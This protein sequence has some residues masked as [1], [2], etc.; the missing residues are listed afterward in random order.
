M[1]LLFRA[2]TGCAAPCPTQPG[3][4]SGLLPP[5]GQREEEVLDIPVIIRLMQWAFTE[6]N[7]RPT[8]VLV[9]S[10]LGEK[11]L[12]LATALHSHTVSTYMGPGIFKGL[13]M[14]HFI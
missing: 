2:L 3:P 14:Y 6:Q 4:T 13:Y 9:L 10:G 11:W 8:A 1:T 5:F 7:L 12:V